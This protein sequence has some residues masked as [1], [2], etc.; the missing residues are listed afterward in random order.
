MADLGFDIDI[1]GTTKLFHD[2]LNYQS[3]ESINV[4]KTKTFFSFL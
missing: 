3:L 4:D 2:I 1:I